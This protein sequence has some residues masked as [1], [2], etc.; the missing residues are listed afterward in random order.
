[1]SSNRIELILRDYGKRCWD[2]QEG[3]FFYLPV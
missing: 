3:R 2:K 1:M